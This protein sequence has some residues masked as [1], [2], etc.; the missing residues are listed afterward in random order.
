MREKWVVM[1][2]KR[3]IG[4]RKTGYNARKRVDRATPPLTMAR[5]RYF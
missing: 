2:E 4:S 3:L 1:M 5:Y